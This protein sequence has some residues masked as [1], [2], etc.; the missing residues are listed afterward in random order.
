MQVLIVSVVTVVTA[1]ATEI[2]KQLHALLTTL[3]ANAPSP[4]AL[5]VVVVVVAVGVVDGIGVWLYFARGSRFF[6]LV[7]TLPGH[8]TEYGSNTDVE[9]EMLVSA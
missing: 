5:L 9:L 8:S 7:G 6:T 2:D 1:V 4:A 3:A